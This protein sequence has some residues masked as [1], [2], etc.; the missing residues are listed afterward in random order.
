MIIW[1]FEGV[2]GRIESKI[3]TWRVCALYERGSE[4]WRAAASGSALL[5]NLRRGGTKFINEHM[6][7]LP[8]TPC[9][10]VNKR[11]KHG[12]GGAGVI[13]CTI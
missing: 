7:S 3:L 2:N 4:E 11:S 6:L 12:W 10:S 8:L 9:Y 13:G 5:V 1:S